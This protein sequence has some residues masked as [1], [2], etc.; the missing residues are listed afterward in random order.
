MLTAAVS[1]AGDRH[2]LSSQS[3]THSAGGSLTLL[4]SGQ[5]SLEGAECPSAPDETLR[6]FLTYQEDTETMGQLLAKFLL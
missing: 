6:L 5:E 1:Q 3:H 2:E 4:P